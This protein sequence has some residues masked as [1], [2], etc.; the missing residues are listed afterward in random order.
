MSEPGA[1]DRRYEILLSGAV[2]Q[3]LRAVQRRASEIGQ[4]EAALA[5]FRQIIDRLHADASEAG[6]PLY[7]LPVLRM[8]IRCIVIRPVI[9]DYALVE[10]RPIVFIKG[11]R[12]I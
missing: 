8:Q 7:R 3:A 9:V 6:E 5:A 1:G 2:A 4:G 12:L 10:D 11:A